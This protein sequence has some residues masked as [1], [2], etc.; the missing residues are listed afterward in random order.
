M[1]RRQRKMIDAKQIAREGKRYHAFY[2]GCRARRA[3]ERRNPFPAGSEE[4][5]YWRNGWKYA[6]G[7]E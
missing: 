5:S 4:F 6:E 3:G 2:R 7:R 1:N